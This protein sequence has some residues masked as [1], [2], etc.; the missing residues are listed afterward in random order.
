MEMK[1]GVGLH[2]LDAYS[3]DDIV[4]QIKLIESL[5]YDQ[6]WISNEKVLS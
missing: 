6:L 4:E 5:G 2:W 3:Y 1:L